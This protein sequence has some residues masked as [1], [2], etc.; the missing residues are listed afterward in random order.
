MLKRERPVEENVA[1]FYVRDSP[2][3]VCFVFSS[4]KE[5]QEL[6]LEKKR[7]QWDF[8]LQVVIS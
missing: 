7:R 6:V 1:T 4:R 3:L 5:E 2:F 8:E